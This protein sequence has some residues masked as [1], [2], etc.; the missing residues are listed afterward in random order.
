MNILARNLTKAILKVIGNI[1]EVHDV[2]KKLQ[3]GLG[4]RNLHEHV[5][6]YAVMRVNI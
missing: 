2:G 3:K 6:A 5:Y 4:I 1:R